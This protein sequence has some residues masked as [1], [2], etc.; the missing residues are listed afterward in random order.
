MALSLEADWWGRLS[1]ERLRSESR[2]LREAIDRRALGSTAEKAPE[3][4]AALVAA[5]MD[6][7]LSA[8]SEAFKGQWEEYA[9]RK[10]GILGEHNS[11]EA[12]QWDTF[13]GSMDKVLAE[14]QGLLKT[15]AH[16]ASLGERFGISSD[17]P[18]LCEDLGTKVKQRM[19]KDH[20]PGHFRLRKNNGPKS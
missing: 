10:G 12:A 19:L 2:E 1:V 7:A 16:K 8:V 13:L 9:K 17:R 11:Q 15:E 18:G 6:E 20:A 14:A 5:E 4:L 3:V